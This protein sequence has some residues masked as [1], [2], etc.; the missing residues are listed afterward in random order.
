[1]ARMNETIQT[2]TVYALP[3]LFAITVHEASHA[4]AARYFGDSTA[5]LQGRMTLNPIKHID[6]IG[7]LLIP[8]LLFVVGSPYLFGYAKPV[9]VEWGNLGKPKRDMGWVALAG[10][11]SNLVMAL[12]WMVLWLVLWGI[13]LGEAFF[14]RM[15]EAGVMVNLVI[16]A[17]NLFPVP[18]LDGG[19]IVTSLLPHHA[20]YRYAKLEPYGFFIIL[21]LLFLGG[22]HYW[23]RPVTQAGYEI[24]SLLVAPLKFL[25]GL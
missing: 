7:T 21:G 25:L 22:L 19:R 10:P 18:P 14:L 16:F 9:P 17:L 4:Y 23:L 1:M 20:S 13:N 5:Y 2:L 3:L 11:A 6:P 8:I 24:I 15:A 12:L